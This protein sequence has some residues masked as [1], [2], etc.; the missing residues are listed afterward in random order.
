MT[1]ATLAISGN[2]DEPRLLLIA[3]GNG[4]DRKSDANFTSFVGILSVPDAFLVLRDFRIKF[5]SLE[6]TCL[7]EAKV[8]LT[9]KRLFTDILFS[10]LIML[11]WLER[12]VRLFSYQSLHCDKLFSLVSSQWT[13]LQC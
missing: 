11:E 6:V 12:Y 9:H 4:F 7:A 1:V 5:T 8:L 10:I 13:V 2:L 3:V